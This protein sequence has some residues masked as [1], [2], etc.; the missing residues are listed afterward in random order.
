M[1]EQLIERLDNW[2][3]LN[4]PDYYLHLLPGATDS[5]INKV[6]EA[7]GVQLPASF[8]AFLKWKNGQDD[9]TK[10]LENYSLV[11]CNG[12]LALWNSLNSWQEDGTFEVENWWSRYWV[13]FLYDFTGN[14]VCID[15]KGF[16]NGKPGQVI[17]YWHDEYSRDIIHESFYK[18]L[19]TV[20][21][22]MES[23]TIY[24]GQDGEYSDYLD[25]RARINPG[26][27]I[28]VNLEE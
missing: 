18:W 11:S 4:R 21:L 2:L 12:I 17:D 7:L 6:E 24:Y 20:V 23:G 19:E 26:Y 3:R 10:F 28:K 22:A 14:H 9:D 8:K 13:P 1:N 5:E 27:P 16:L 15:T 25:F